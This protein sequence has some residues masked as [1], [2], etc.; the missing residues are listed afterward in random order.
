MPR[1]RSTR[2]ELILREERQ[3]EIVAK[4][5][6]LGAEDVAARVLHCWCDRLFGDSNQHRY[7]CRS[8]SCLF[9]R[10][11]ASLSAWFRAYS[12]WSCERGT[13]S[14]FSLAFDDCLS[15]LPA[16]AK[17]L[18]NLRDRLARER[19]WLFADLAFAGLTDGRAIHVIVSHPKLSREQVRERLRTLWPGVI[20]GDVPAAPV[21]AMSPRSLAQIGSLRRGLQPLRFSISSRNC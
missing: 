3:A 14:Y 10:N 8:V 16:L 18:R 4:L 20:L 9:C 5:I 2:A 1:R 11:K 15:E 17:G 19:S 12:R 13:R 7:R 6:G 21:F